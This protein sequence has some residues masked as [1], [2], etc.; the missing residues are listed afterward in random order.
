MA[1]CHSLGLDVPAL[2]AEGE[3]GSALI[4]GLPC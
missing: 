2:D 3:P 4:A 1:Q